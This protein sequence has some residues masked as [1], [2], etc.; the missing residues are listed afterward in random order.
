M[1]TPDEK[2]LLDRISNDQIR[3]ERRDL[4]IAVLATALFVALFLAV[5]F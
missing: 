5:T 4:A 3:I 1:N 2:L